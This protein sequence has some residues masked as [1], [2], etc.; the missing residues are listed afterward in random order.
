PIDRARCDVG[1]GTDSLRSVLAGV[2]KATA[3]MAFAL[4]RHHLAAEERNDLGIRRLAE[5]TRRLRFPPPLAGAIHRQ[6]CSAFPQGP[7]ACRASLGRWRRPGFAAE[8]VPSCPSRWR[9]AVRDLRA[10]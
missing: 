10:A 6:A 9:P 4:H 7:A 1:G 5:R 2:E 3:A 8:S